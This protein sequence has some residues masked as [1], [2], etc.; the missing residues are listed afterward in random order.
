M[1]H[2]IPLDIED[3]V[4]R[5]REYFDVHLI[6]WRDAVVIEHIEDQVNDAVATVGRRVLKIIG[7][8]TTVRRCDGKI[9]K[10]VFML[11]HRGVVNNDVVSRVNRQVQRIHLRA[12]I[13]IRVAIGVIATSSV[14]FTIPSICLTS[15]FR[16]GGM[17]WVVDGQVERIHTR[18]AIGVV[19]AVGIGA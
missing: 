14:S 10:R 19:V 11:T 13:G 12:T 7:I 8:D 1:P 6:I 9:A 16:N 3:G 5:I 15:G 17:H 18:A 2:I 4:G